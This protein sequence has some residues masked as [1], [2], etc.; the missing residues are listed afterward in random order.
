MSDKPEYLK[1]KLDEIPKPLRDRPQW[2]LWAALER[3]GK[4]T[5]P[6]YSVSKGGSASTTN[7]KTWGSFD[8][9]EASYKR[10]NGFDGIG[11]S[12]PFLGLQRRKTG[13]NRYS[14]RHGLGE[15]AVPNTCHIRGSP[16]SW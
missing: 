4:W 13:Y 9:V 7:P 11:I 2:V 10:L 3:N 1:P 15:L 5:K 6:L 16:R 8:R 12:T 14:S